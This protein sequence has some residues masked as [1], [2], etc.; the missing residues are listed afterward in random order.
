V[1]SIAISS[2]KGGV[3]KTT[4]A[5]NLAYSMA[6]RGWQTLLVDTDPQ[7][8]VGLSLSRR[9]RYCRG[10]YDALASVEEADIGK[11]ILS[12]RL[13]E[14]KILTAGQ[15]ESF[16]KLDSQLAGH[17][18]ANGHGEEEKGA[19]LTE[20]VSQLA[21]KVGRIGFDMV[22][23]DTAAGVFGYTAQVLRCVDYVLIPQ[24][25]EPLGVRS[26][27]QILQM[28]AH[29]REDDARL[30]VLGVL[31]TMMQVDQAQ[32]REVARELRQVLTRELLLNTD[33]PRDE[34]FLKASETGVP[35][36]LLY[37]HP[38]ES[39]VVFDRLAAELESRMK[40]NSTNDKNEYTRLMD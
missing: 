22:I 19:S 5:I 24:Q 30:K 37:R 14:L 23:F 8:A 32:C 34:I 29:L 27:P 40:L 16:F 17:A 33:I 38:P 10:Y 7:G 13:P 12:T 4:V 3:G 26:I 2:Q 28:I 1:I 18:S 35:V 15:S 20:R 25:A 31:L 9:A 6:R 21:E 11:M 39:A 36:G